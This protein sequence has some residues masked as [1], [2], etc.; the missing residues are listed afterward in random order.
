M[1]RGYLVA[2]NVAQAG[3]WALLLARLLL[4]PGKVKTGEIRLA[5][6]LQFFA[7]LEVIHSLLGL[8][9]S[10]TLTA[11]LQW[12][13]RFHVIAAVVAPIEEIQ[14]SPCLVTLLGAWSLSEV[15]RYPQ[16]VA[17]ILGTCPPWLT[18]ARYSGFIVLYPIG[19]FS[20]MH[21]M[22]SALPFI[23]KENMY[24]SFFRWAPFG[25][26]GFIMALLVIYP[27][28]ALFLYAHMLSQRRA[29]LRLTPERKRE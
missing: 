18:W 17:S 8:V 26:H 5:Y 27:G 7:L 22:Y 10:G 12:G 9:R 20:E 16:Y 24:S 14:N 13:G 6:F 2:Y 19:F 3:G 28:F 15:I 11:L 23:R 29:K 21:L 1:A 25:Y 4:A